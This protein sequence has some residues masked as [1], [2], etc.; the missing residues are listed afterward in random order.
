MYNAKS[1]ISTIIHVSV[2]QIREMVDQQA[3]LGL[4]HADLQ[5]CLAN[6]TAMLQRQNDTTESQ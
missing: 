1:S 3:A 4:Q 2:I 6:T 5:I